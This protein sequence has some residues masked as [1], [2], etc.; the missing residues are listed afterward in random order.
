MPEPSPAHRP[1]HWGHQHWSY[2][3]VIMSLAFGPLTHF[4]TDPC[5][6]AHEKELPGRLL[7]SVMLPLSF[8]NNQFLL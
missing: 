2:P 6:L 7:A 3:P 1:I 4:Q 8:P 5:D